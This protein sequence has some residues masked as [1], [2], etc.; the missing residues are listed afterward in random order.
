MTTE[1]RIAE[2]LLRVT[3]GK[4]KLTQLQ[5]K[6]ISDIVKGKL[7]LYTIH[8]MKYNHVINKWE[9]L[10]TIRI[11]SDTIFPLLQKL[12][13]VPPRKEFYQYV[14]YDASNNRLPDVYSYNPHLF[15]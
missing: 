12:T 10:E 14:I 3:A 6:E 1:K 9:Q 13:P 7:L 2:Y 15:N 4:V 8:K 5:C 11:D